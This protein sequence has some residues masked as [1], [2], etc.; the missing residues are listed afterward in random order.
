MSVKNTVASLRPVPLPLPR[1]GAVCARLRA[2]RTIR[3]PA[4]PA[5]RALPPL[6]DG[7][8][9]PRHHPGAILLDAAA[10]AGR[11]EALAAEVDRTYAQT[12]QPVVLVCVLKG[13]LMF[14]A[15]L[16]RAMTVPMEIDT[17]A[18]RSYVAGRQSS[19]VVELV[20]DVGI[21]LGDRDVLIVEDIIDT[22]LTTSFIRDHLRAHRPRSLR[23]ITLLD[24]PARRASEVSID[25]RGFTIGD[26]FVVG[27][28][29]DLDERWRELPDL[30]TLDGA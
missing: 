13:S 26:T 25:F 5:G 20:K 19:G 8:Q 27:Y 29:L 15:D 2:R 24:K 9:V 6:C 22:G 12:A 21:A 7:P 23:L 1:M 10:I 14:T 3:Q 4:N 18:V 30:R 17:I 11:V 28:G 16:A